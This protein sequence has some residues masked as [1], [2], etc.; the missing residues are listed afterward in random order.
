M[1]GFVKR[2]LTQIQKIN[3][4][5]SAVN[6]LY[7]G[8][9][10]SNIPQIVDSALQIPSG[11]INLADAVR[12]ELT[13]RTIPKF[14]DEFTL[15]NGLPTNPIFFNTLPIGKVFRISSGI[16]ISLRGLEKIVKSSQAVGLQEPT[17]Q[18]TTIYSS[19]GNTAESIFGLGNILSGLTNIL[20]GAF[21]TNTILNLVQ[22]ICPNLPLQTQILITQ[23]IYGLIGTLSTVGT[24]V[25]SNLQ[26]SSTRDD[27]NRVV[28]IDSTA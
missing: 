3:A 24:F 10:F 22:S 15:K 21:G 27:L 16:Y 26:Y 7:F 12:S 23:T 1:S 18:P 20:N 9:P 19:I 8:N 4:Q 11:W 25:D 28:V 2:P 5:T 13:F 14:E 17:N 6:N